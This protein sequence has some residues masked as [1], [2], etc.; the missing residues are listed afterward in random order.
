MT[1]CSDSSRERGDA[2]LATAPPTR[3]WLLLE[4]P[5]PWGPSGLLDSRLSR[6]VARALQDRADAAGLRVLLIRR[7]GRVTDTD[8]IRRW[9]VVRST[10]NTAEW[11]HWDREERLVDGPLPDADDAR[12]SSVGEPT[13]LVCTHG[14]HD[15]CCAIRGRPVAHELSAGRPNSTW[16][17]SHVGGDRFAANVVVLPWGLYYGNVEADEVAT[18]TEVTDAGR[19]LVPRFRGRAGLPLPAQAAQQ[20]V[21]RTLGIDGR[22]E[23]AVE[24]VD[25]T[26]ADS[27][28]VALAG[29]PVLAVS[30]H[31]VEVPDGLTCAAAGP[32]GVWHWDVSPA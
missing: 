30:R 1:R 12:T 20:H 29:Q 3:G 8:G 11:C 18:L 31:R 23:L 15:V 10:T 9:A 2:L 7:A 14:K 5:G 19:V 13:Y 16:E 17:C 21:R 24:A 6:P 27:W 4:L 32:A 28:T 26:G 25:P 22:D